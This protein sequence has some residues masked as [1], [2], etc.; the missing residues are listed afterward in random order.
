MNRNC[1]LKTRKKR[2]HNMDLNVI[3]PPPSVPVASGMFLRF[4]FLYRE[5]CPFNCRIL[6][7]LLSGLRIWKL[8]HKLILHQLRWEDRDQESAECVNEEPI[9]RTNIYFYMVLRIQFICTQGCGITSTRKQE[10]NGCNWLI[11]A[12]FLKPFLNWCFAFRFSANE[13]ELVHRIKFKVSLA[14]L[15]L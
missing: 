8:Q 7:V 13:L 15:V 12:Y 5:I 2:N 1:F 9:K 4:C 14:E 3:C 11:R 6:N 10:E